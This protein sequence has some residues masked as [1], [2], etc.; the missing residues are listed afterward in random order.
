M[1]KQDVRIGIYLQD[2][3]GIFTVT[4]SFFTLF[5]LNLHNSQ[6]IRLT[7]EMV[8][9]LGFTESF[10]SLYT[11]T[12]WC[13]A[14]IKKKG[15]DSYFLVTSSYVFYIIEVNYVHELQNLFY[16]TAKKHLKFIDNP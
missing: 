2:E 8:K 16:S 13:F 10:N 7:D 9:N 11:H 6:P 15:L 12:D 5:D 3:D 4:E 1:E 14:L